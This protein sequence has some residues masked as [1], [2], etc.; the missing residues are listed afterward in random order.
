MFTYSEG[1]NL[2]IDFKG[3]STIEI[4]SD[5]KL[6][7]K[8]IEKDLTELEYKQEKIEQIDENRVYVTISDV[9]DNDETNKVEKYF[10]EKYEAT[11]SVG[12][13]SN[14]VKKDIT[15][16]KSYTYIYYHTDTC[17]Y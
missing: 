10:N 1:L 4:N 7:L 11:T 13:I 6:P 3:G 9:L 14:Q 5:N 16:F 12:A 15:K 8:D 17:I 2:G